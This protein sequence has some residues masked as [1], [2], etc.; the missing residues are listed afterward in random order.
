MRQPATLPL[1]QTK[2]SNA[3]FSIAGIMRFIG[4]LDKRLDEATVKD[5]TVVHMMNDCRKFF[6]FRKSVEL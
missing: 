5:W 6:A 2:L 3:K 1:N 4:Q